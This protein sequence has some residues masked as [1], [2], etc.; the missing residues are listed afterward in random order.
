MENQQILS[1]QSE[2]K[3]ASKKGRDKGLSKSVLKKAKRKQRNEEEKRL[4]EI[5]QR[6]SFSENNT[7]RN[8][9]L[10]IAA[11]AAFD[12]NGLD[13]NLV[14][15]TGTSCKEEEA[16]A[17]RLYELTEANMK[18]LYL[19]NEWIWT[20]ARKRRELFHEDA[21][22]L[23]AQGKATGEVVGF[24]HFRFLLEDECPVLYVYELQVDPKF[25]R[26][27]LGRHLMICAELIANKYKLEWVMLTAFKSNTASQKFF[28]G[29]RYDID[30]TSPQF[31][32]EDMFDNDEATYDI[33]SKKTRH[34][35]T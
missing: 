16:L 21:R 18:H 26:K 10:D 23:I 31:S 3:D 30:E 13:L 22:L 28:R 19:E 27:K 4:R 25:S 2:T 14:F 7:P 20:E 17:D 8:V 32:F 29:L 5:I 6:A 11:L 33:L 12:R 34:C 35:K 1:N 15:H 24:I 9:L